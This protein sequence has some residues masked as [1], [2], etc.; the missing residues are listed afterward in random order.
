MGEVLVD[1]LLHYW[2]WSGDNEFFEN[3]AYE[4]VKGHLRFQEETMRV[5]GTQLYENFLNAWNTDNKW[6]NGGPGTIAS[7]YTWRVYTVMSQIAQKLGKREDPRVFQ[8]KAG[9]IR[10]DMKESLWDGDKGVYGEYRDFFG[11]KRLH[12]APDLSSVYTPIDV[13]M[14]GWEESCQMLHYVDTEFDSI[15]VEDAEFPYSSNWKPLFY[16][17]F[18]LYAQEALNYALVCFRTGQ[19]KKGYGIYKGCLIP[20]Y[21]GKGAGPGAA[22][23]TLNENLENTGHIDFSETSSLYIRTAVEGLF[24]IMVKKSQGIVEICPGFP[25]DWTHAAISI[26]DISYRFYHK[27]NEDVFIIHS[28]APLRLVMKVPARSSVV[29][30]VWVNDGAAAFSL[31]EAVTFETEPLTEARIVVRYGESAPA[32]ICGEKTAIAGREYLLTADGRI[33]GIKDPQGI[34]TGGAELPSSELLVHLGK[35]TG[36]HTFFVEVEKNMMKSVFPVN[37][38]LE[39]DL[40]EDVKAK[41]GD[42]KREYKTIS[43]GKCVNQNLRRLHENRYDLTWEGNPHYV[44]PNFYFCR[45]TTRTVTTTGRSWWEDLSRGKNGVPES[46]NLSEEGGVYMTEAGI[47]FLVA[48]EGE[49]K[50]NAVFVSLYNQF[51][52]EISIPVNRMGSSI[53]FMLAVSTNS[54]QSRIENA[55]ITVCFVDGTEKNLPLIN[56][57]NIDDWLCYQGNRTN[58]WD[59]FEKAES[60]AEEG[61]IQPLGEKAHANILSME[62]EQEKEITSVKFQCLSNEVLA[63]ILGITVGGKDGK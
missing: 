26:P 62:W 51:P 39:L 34:L 37:L 45:D 25:E 32:S 16:S 30:G 42:G 57:D 38:K 8:E 48:A 52:D 7:A 63:G 46:L 44:L 55:R 54:M 33:T 9:A 4:F 3:E 23:H 19:R 59:S 47:P 49:E 43:L 1:Q 27:G 12:N 35:K 56:P 10:A 2:I 6:T 28:I 20:L 5:P 61:E 53:Y 58:D 13:G 21:K 36:Y 29:E 40:G 31:S 14:T 22:S 17:S 50:Q 15:V 60:W 24:G 41:Q 11:L 18:G